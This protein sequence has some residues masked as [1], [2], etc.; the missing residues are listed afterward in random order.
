[1]YTNS[2]ILFFRSQWRFHLIIKL[3]RRCQYRDLPWRS[4]LSWSP[5]KMKLLTWILNLARGQNRCPFLILDQ[6]REKYIPSHLFS[7]PVA[8]Y[9]SN[10]YTPVLHFIFC[11]DLVSWVNPCFVFIQ[12]ACGISEKPNS[13]IDEID[14]P[15]VNNHLCVVE[16]VEELYTFYKQQQV[17]SIIYKI[18]L[19]V[20]CLYTNLMKAWILLFL[21]VLNSMCVGRLNT[22]TSSGT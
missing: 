3:H 7:Q 15:D 9:V 8:R 20:Q 11:K 13:Q 22:W 17:L 21:F 6:R 19:P 16:Y 18:S 5:N 12:V 2:F 4:R 1:M 14:L 10:Y